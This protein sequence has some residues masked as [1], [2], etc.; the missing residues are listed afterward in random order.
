MLYF[1]YLIFSLAP[2]AYATTCE[3]PY[4]PYPFQ[5]LINFIQKRPEFA[6]S[7]SDVK[8]AHCRKDFPS[9]DDIN[10]YF[11]EVNDGYELVEETINGLDIK[12]Q[13]CG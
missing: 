8:Q 12:A 5:D 3:D 7:A 11:R 1:V 13:I 10:S 9:K 4:H 2:L 6:A